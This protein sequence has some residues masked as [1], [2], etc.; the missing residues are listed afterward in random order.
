MTYSITGIADLGT[1][2]SESFNKDANLF[3]IPMP[4]EDSDEAIVFD[5]FGPEATLRIE[6]VFTGTNAQVLTFIASLQGLINGAQDTNVDYLSDTGMPAF[7]GR[8]LS[9]NWSRDEGSISMVSYTIAI[10]ECA[11]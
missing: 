10:M 11:A 5:L 1:V 3:K 6:G 4:R 9:V 7:S 8:V 2:K